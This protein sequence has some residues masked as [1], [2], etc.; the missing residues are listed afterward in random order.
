MRAPPRQIRA[1][2]LQKDQPA[3]IYRPD[4]RSEGGA[5]GLDAGPIVFRR[6]GAFF[7]EHVSRPP[8]SPQDAGAMDARVDA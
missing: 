2:F 7:F 3:S 6:A 5:L 1:R 8:Q 4:P